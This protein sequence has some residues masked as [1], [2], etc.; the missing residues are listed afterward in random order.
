MQAL[1]ESFSGFEGLNA[2][3][4]GISPDDVETHRKFSKEL[5]LHFPLIADTDQKIRKLYRPGRITFVID[6]QGVVRFIQEGMPNTKI[7]LEE[8]RKIGS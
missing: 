5:G 2:Q 6:R 1:Q 8:I 7:L 3:V 4:L